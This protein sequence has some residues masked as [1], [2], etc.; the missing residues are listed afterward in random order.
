MSLFHAGVTC[1][2]ADGVRRLLGPLAVD[3]ALGRVLAGGQGAAAVV[4]ALAA[5]LVTGSLPPTEA[6]RATCASSLPESLAWRDQ[7]QCHA[8]GI[9][10]SPRPV[11]PCSPPQSRRVKSCKPTPSWACAIFPRL[12]CRNDSPQCWLIPELA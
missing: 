2:G 1:G 6:A 8:A 10:A 3:V 5:L 4:P 7:C 9:R 11:G 12:D